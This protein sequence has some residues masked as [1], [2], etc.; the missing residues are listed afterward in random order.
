LLAGATLLQAAPIYLRLA[1]AG[2]LE[3]DIWLIHLTGE[4]FPA[5]SMGARQFCRSLVEKTLQLKLDD[6]KRIDLSGT[7]IVGV[8]VMDMIGHNR[9]DDQ[10]HFSNLPG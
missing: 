10:K 2:K 3:R 5:D 1:K 7:E 8:Y 9:D 4:E 6:G